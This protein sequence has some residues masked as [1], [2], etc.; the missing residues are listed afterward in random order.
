MVL[1]VAASMAL[2]A[3]ATF[4]VSTGA[5]PPVTGNGKL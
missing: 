3:P 5:A 1:S 4:V 2:A